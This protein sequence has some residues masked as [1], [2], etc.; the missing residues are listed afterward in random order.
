MKKRSRYFLGLVV[1]GVMSLAIMGAAFAA[2]YIPVGLENIL[3]NNQTTTDTTAP[4]TTSGIVQMT[5]GESAQEVVAVDEN[6][7]PLYHAQT[8]AA[9]NGKKGQPAYIAINGKVYEVSGVINWVGGFHHGYQAG[10][11]LTEAFGHSPHTMSI[12]KN[13]PIVGSYSD[14]PSAT[15][16][17]LDTTTSSVTESNTG[18]DDTTTAVIDDVSEKSLIESTVENIQ[19]NLL[20]AAS[21]LISGETSSGST[22]FTKETLKA[23][24]G[25][26]GQ[27]AYIAINGDVYDVSG[28]IDWAG[29]FHHGY[30]AGQDLTTA[31]GH[32]PHTLS[33]LKLANQVGTYSEN[34]VIASD[35]STSSNTTTTNSSTPTTT[36]TTTSTND[37]MTAQTTTESAISSETKVVLADTNSVDNT[38]PVFTLS[39]LSAYN[40]MNGKAAYIAVNGIIYDVTREWN[41]G[42]HHGLTAGTDVTNAFAG[43]PHSSSLLATLTQVGTLLESEQI[44]NAAITNPIP[45]ATVTDPMVYDDDHEDYDDDHE[46]YEDHEDHEDHED[47]DDDHERHEDEHDEEDD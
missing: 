24:D 9:Y 16:D 17:T 12:L 18:Q 6:G 46:E 8:L 45:G 34:G 15:N 28:I 2:V 10:Q 37:T 38:L 19:D 13:V 36:S 47:R 22:I 33:I 42:M 25:K 44:T 27:P 40:G 26:N 3:T 30:Q 14:S 41:N 20:A 7:L 35:T 21:A 29:G 39:E 23:Y 11:D 31:F 32:S 1:V 4:N 5:N 43:S